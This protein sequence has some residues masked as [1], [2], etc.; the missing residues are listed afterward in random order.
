MSLKYAFIP[1]E[2][3]KQ[4]VDSAFWNDIEKLLRDYPHSGL[5]NLYSF[6]EKDD[7]DMSSLY[8]M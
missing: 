5:E 8:T 2:S 7:A 1:D 6:D 4:L 3:E